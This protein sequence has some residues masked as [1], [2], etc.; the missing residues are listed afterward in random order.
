MDYVLI[1]LTLIAVMATVIVALLVRQK[2]AADTSSLIKQDI[3]EL[4]RTIELLKDNLQTTVSE[5]LDK[6]QNLMQTSMQR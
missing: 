5:R 1:V 3:T 4:G 6:S 2:P